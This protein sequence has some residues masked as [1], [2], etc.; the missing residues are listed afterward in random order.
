MK[1]VSFL[2]RKASSTTWRHRSPKIRQCDDS[3]NNLRDSSY[4]LVLLRNCWIPFL[5]RSN[6]VQ[7]RS[8]SRVIQKL[9]THTRSLQKNMLPCI[10]IYIILYVSYIY[11]GFLRKP[12]SVNV[13]IP[14]MSVRRHK[15]S[16]VRLNVKD[17][18]GSPNILAETIHLHKHKFFVFATKNKILFLNNKQYNFFQTML[19]LR[20]APICLRQGNNFWKLCFQLYYKLARLTSLIEDNFVLLLLPSFFFFTT[21]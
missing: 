6:P 5:I 19:L 7:I 13:E 20:L 9:S 21:R 15:C 14:C 16:W 10:I 11:H 8:V 17:H 3:T 18:Y 4:N 12:F 2:L 1:F